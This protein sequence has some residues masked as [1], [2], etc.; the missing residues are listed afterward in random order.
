MAAKYFALLLAA[1]LALAP[2]SGFPAKSQG[3]LPYAAE[4][5]GTVSRNSRS[6]LLGVSV[7][8]VRHTNMCRRMGWI[9]DAETAAKIGEI[10]IDR[11]FG[12]AN[13]RSSE[14]AK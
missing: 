5:S 7:A 4:A 12:R 13:L 3:I 14:L 2:L 8:S 1:V 10:I 6:L 11:F 9:P